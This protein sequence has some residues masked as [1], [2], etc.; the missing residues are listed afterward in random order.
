MPRDPHDPD[1]RCTTCDLAT[2]RNMLMLCCAVEIHAVEIH[3]HAL[4][5]TDIAGLAQVPV[6]F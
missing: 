2:A 5:Q 3:P 6:P 4:Q 1:F